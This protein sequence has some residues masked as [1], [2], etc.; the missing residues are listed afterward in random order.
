ML[1]VLFMGGKGG[2]STCH[3]VKLVLMRGVCK[4]FDRKNGVIAIFFNKVSNYFTL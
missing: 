1:D 4:F 2:D 3:G